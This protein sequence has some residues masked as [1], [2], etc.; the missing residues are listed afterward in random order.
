MWYHKLGL[1]FIFHQKKRTEKF[2]KKEGSLQFFEMRKRLINAITSENCEH[3]KNRSEW[4]PRIRERKT[5]PKIRGYRTKSCRDGWTRSEDG[6]PLRS[7]LRWNE[8]DGSRERVPKIHGKIRGMIRGYRTRS[9]GGSPLQWSL[10]WNERDDDPRKMRPK[11]KNQLGTNRLR[12]DGPMRCLST[13][14]HRIPRRTG[15]RWHKQR[16]K[17]KPKQSTYV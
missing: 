1:L 8:R 16:P 4:E 6:S 2:H 14:Q 7:N 12:C 10:R 11:E 13:G 3:P 17:D 9:E 15:L 5:C